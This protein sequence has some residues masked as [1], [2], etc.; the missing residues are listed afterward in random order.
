MSGKA[1]VELVSVIM[2]ACEQAL[3]R[4]EKQLARQIDT[5]NNVIDNTKK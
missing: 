1:R 4:A 2:H 5:A 3:S